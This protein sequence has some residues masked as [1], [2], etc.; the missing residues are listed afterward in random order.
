MISSLPGH[1][2]NSTSNLRPE[3]VGDIRH[4][5]T[6]RMSPLGGQ[7]PRDAAWPVA[8]PRDHCLDGAAGVDANLALVVD[9]TRDSLRRDTG[10]AGD[11]GDGYFHNLT[12]PNMQ[13]AFS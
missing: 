8:K 9:H 7:T 10:F 5:K 1:I 12:Y 13:L 2:L 11:V 4:R 3:W 6:D